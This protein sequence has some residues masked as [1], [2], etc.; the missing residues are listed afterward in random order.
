MSSAKDAFW[1][2]LLL[3][4]AFQM[5]RL[6]APLISSKPLSSGRKREALAPAVAGSRKSEIKGAKLAL[7][8][9]KPTPDGTPTP[10]AVMTCTPQIEIAAGRAF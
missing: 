3:L 10:A 5:Y 8:S 6:S 7:L 9:D 1:S 2:P 4:K